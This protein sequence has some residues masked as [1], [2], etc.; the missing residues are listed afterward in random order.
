MPSIK[1]LWLPLLLSM[2]L[3]PFTHAIDFGGLG[4]KPVSFD[5]ANP[6]TESWFIYEMQPGEIKQDGIRIQN[7]TDVTETI[8]IY[9][10]DST[11]SSDGGFAL[12]QHAEIMSQV[13]SWVT[14]ESN[15]LTLAPGETAIIPLV[16]QVP[17]DVEPGE[18]RGG[19]MI[20]RQ[21]AIENTGEAQGGVRLNLR[22]GVRMYITVPGE[23][24]KK[25]N[26]TD[27]KTQSGENGLYITSISLKNE[28]NVGRMA[29]MELF[30]QDVLWHQK[31]LLKAS[32][33]NASLNRAAHKIQNAFWQPVNHTINR[34]KIEVL[35]NDE[36]TLNFEWEP[37]YIGR[38]MTLAKVTY[39]GQE[40]DEILLSDM[41]YYWILPWQHLRWLG[42]G[43]MTFILFMLLVVILKWM[44][45][46]T[47][48]H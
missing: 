36:T 41:A 21:K 47:V 48:I 29:K 27:L 2:F 31:S 14:L 13:G 45:V 10:A 37:P 46:L 15:Q 42:Y 8:L 5:P 9:P 24:I 30:I 44:L 33:A 7:F 39:E 23:I 1:P 18:H 26:L 34:N 28:G 25:I 20:E 35:R 16:I 12:K 43:L 40:G 22:V 19:I 38:V 4:G 32:E 3:A 6:L 17:A 11:H